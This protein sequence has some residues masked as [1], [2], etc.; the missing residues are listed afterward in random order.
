M[1]IIDQQSTKDTLDAADKPVSLICAFAIKS[2]E[3]I[4]RKHFESVVKWSKVTHEYDTPDADLMNK[5]LVVI[6]LLNGLVKTLGR[7][8][9]NYY[10]ALFDY[11]IGFLEHCMTVA[12]PVSQGKRA[13]ASASAELV[14]LHSLTLESLTLLF[15]H[16]KKGFVDNL[17]FEKLVKPL[18]SQLKLYTLT[19]D[20]T[21]YAQLHVVPAIVA[22]VQL[23]ADDYM[24]KTVLHQ[25][26][27]HLRVD[28][29]AVRKSV[30]ICCSQI[31]D[32]LA[33]R[34]VV[35]LNNF[36]PHLATLLDDEET[37]IAA[38]GRSIAKQINQYS[39]E[40]VFAL[41]K[42]SL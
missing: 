37:E 25:V 30:A 13:T 14:A 11:F 16:D 26:C 35:V 7:F 33:E 15:K 20:W 21:A 3:N 22:L 6:K 18:T 29:I 24:W 27:V 42:Q 31:V 12:V 5:K 34:F 2:S 39:S 10:G 8:G 36:I 41:I 38:L 1:S 28:S 17:R 19:D 9:I 40:D 32:C 23:A 4:F